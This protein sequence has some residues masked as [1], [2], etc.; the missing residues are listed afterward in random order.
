MW[1]QKKP[2]FNLPLK[3]LLVT[4]SIILL[5]GAMFGPIYALFVEDIG[6]DLMDAS[7]AGGIFALAAG[8]TTL[9][10]G[11]YSDRV[12]ENELIVVAGYM[13]MGLGFL[14]LSICTSVWFLLLIQ[15]L[16]GLGEAV[17]SPAFDAV[18][19]KHLDK[20]HAGKQWGAWESINYFSLAVGAVV[21]G[22]IVT[23]TNFN[24]LFILMA[25]MSFASG[26]YIYLLPRKVL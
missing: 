14:L 12:K 1:F 21:G 6:G 15:I 8:I 7:F 24:V 10:S 4:N 11:K 22:V 20:N 13:I 9:V 16:I 26:I 19:S 3:I 18:Y 2:L 25:M 5:A 23:L 17:Y